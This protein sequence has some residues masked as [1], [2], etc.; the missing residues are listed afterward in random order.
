MLLPEKLAALRK[1]KGLTLRE[2]SEQVGITAAALSTYEKGQKEP[3]LSFAIRL[4]QFYG[5]TLDNLCGL[6]SASN[7]MTY[8]D[9][10]RFVLNLHEQMDIKIVSLGNGLVQS[11]GGYLSR[12]PW[13]NANIEMNSYNPSALE[14]K[15]VFDSDKV[16][17]F[18][19][20]YA[21]LDSLWKGG[22]IPKSVFDSWLAQS[23]KN[24]EEWLVSNDNIPVTIINFNDEG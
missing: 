10:F 4:A 18:F 16:A 24:A 23:L 3:S 20:T 19:D 12:V 21:K 8:A 2:L 5:K 11:E 1:E 7:E 15:L 14:L 9:I 6:E 13:I 22:Q 17:E